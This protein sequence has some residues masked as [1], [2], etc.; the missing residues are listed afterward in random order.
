MQDLELKSLIGF[1]GNPPKGL[2]AHPDGVHLVYPLGTSVTAFNWC[3]RTQRFFVGHS[4]V[5]SALAVSRSGRYVG[6]GQ[7]RRSS[8]TFGRDATSR[9]RVPIAEDIFHFFFCSD[10]NIL[11]S[12]RNKNVTVVQ[13]CLFLLLFFFSFYLTGYVVCLCICLESYKATLN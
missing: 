5:I 3:T 12:E 13:W 11:D 2:I 4:N 10:T 7:V 9:R 8:R 6:A 1:D